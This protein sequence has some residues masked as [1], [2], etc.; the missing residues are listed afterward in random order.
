VPTPRYITDLRRTFG[1]GRLLLP[2]VNGVVLQGEEDAQRILL[3]RR[4]DNGRW[5]LPAGI[6]EPDEQP[7]DCLIREIHEETCVVARAERLVL[8]RTEPEIIYPNGDRC[9]FVSMTFRCAYVDGVAQ[10]GDEESTGVRWFE[11]SALPALGAGELRRIECALA[12]P[13]PTQFEVGPAAD[14]STTDDRR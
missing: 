4:A 6:L 3:V 1:Q 9:Q 7:A 14:S 5:S 10:V 12:P 2:G 8:L 11:L 13:G